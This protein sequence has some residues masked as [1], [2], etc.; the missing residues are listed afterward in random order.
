MFYIIFIFGLCC[1]L[2]ISLVH[3]T[4]QVRAGTL[5][6][7]RYILQTEADVIAFN[8]LRLPYLI[9]RYVRILNFFFSCLFCAILTD[10]R[11]SDL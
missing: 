2:R 10:Q 1:S 11:S 8:S 3:E 4:T 5:R 9:T 6:A 7:V